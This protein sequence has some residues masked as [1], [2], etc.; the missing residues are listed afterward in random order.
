MQHYL[1]ALVKILL[2]WGGYTYRN[3]VL[4]TTYSHFTYH[5]QEPMECLWHCVSSNPLGYGF[6]NLQFLQRR[7]FP[8]TC[9]FLAPQVDLVTGTNAVY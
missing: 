5:L 8:K 6:G 1:G 7:K 9:R 4:L 2:T 3:Y